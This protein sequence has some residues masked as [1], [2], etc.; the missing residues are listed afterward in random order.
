LSE[1][2]RGIKDGARL[3]TGLFCSMAIVGRINLL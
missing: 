3:L 2:I 1:D